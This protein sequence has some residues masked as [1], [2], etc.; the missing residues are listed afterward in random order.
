MTGQQIKAK[1]RECERRA[2]DATQFLHECLVR[3]Q[4]EL[5]IWRARF[6]RSAASV[7]EEAVAKIEGREPDFGP[8]KI[9]G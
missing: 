9:W 1:K 2:F 8:V 3:D 6:P 7:R 4:A 5:A